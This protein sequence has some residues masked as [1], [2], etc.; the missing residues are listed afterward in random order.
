MD[1]RCTW[2]GGRGSA[3][4][5]GDGERRASRAGFANACT[6]YRNW[7]GEGDSLGS[8]MDELPHWEGPTRAG[9]GIDFSYGTE[10]HVIHSPSRKCGSGPGIT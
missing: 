2:I 8:L 3:R 10:G 7:T 5:V 1:T 4:V 9:L 6:G